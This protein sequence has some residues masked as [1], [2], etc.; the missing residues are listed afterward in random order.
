MLPIVPA[1]NFPDAFLNQDFR[2]DI[3]FLWFKKAAEAHFYFEKGKSPSEYRAVLEAETKGF[4]GWLSYHRKHVYV[5]IM[6][7]VDTGKGRMLR[8]RYFSQEIV[9]GGKREVIEFILDYSKMTVGIRE[10]KPGQ[11]VVVSQ[12]IIPNHIVY[13]DVLSA[14]YNLR[15]GVFGLKRKGDV[16]E[17][18]TMP[19]KGVSRITVT[20]ASEEM[21]REKKTDRDDAHYLVR[22]DVDK[23]LFGQ[24]EGIVWVWADRNFVPVMGEVRD[25]VLFGDV[26]GYKKDTAKNGISNRP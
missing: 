20:I 4:I 7:L 15:G 10:S 1:G 22:L 25:V 5:S 9:R 18:D 17:I 13:N 14:Y 2:Y 3:S 6:E 24:R 26:M 12:D 16:F 21:E 8:S 19:R 23:R 11:G